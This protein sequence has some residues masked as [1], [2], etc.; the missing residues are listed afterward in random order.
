MK[1]YLGTYAIF[2]DKPL[3]KAMLLIPGLGRKNIFGFL[4][5]LFPK[6]SVSFLREGCYKDL[7]SEEK[8]HMESVVEKEVLENELGVQF[9]NHTGNPNTVNT[10]IQ[11]GFDETKNVLVL[12]SYVRA[13]ELVAKKRLMASKC[14][15]GRRHR[16]GRKVHG[17]KTKTT[18]RNKIMKGFQKKAKKEQ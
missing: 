8:Q 1:V 7:S 17:Q 2:E 14:L 13:S 11:F 10:G 3:S 18:N 5:S 6:K 12:G 16:A 4:R 15:I 9:C